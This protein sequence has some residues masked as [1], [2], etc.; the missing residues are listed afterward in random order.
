MNPALA[1]CIVGSLRVTGPCQEPLARLGNFGR[2]EWERT[3][4]WLDDS[5][6][7]LYLLER[8]DRAGAHSA[9]PESIRA[10]LRQNL[11]SNRQRLAEMKR[12][13]EF[14]NGRFEAAG[15]EFAALKGFAL[16][17]D[18]CP[19][20]ALRLQYDYDY[21]VRPECEEIARRTLQTA[22]YAHKVQSPGREPQ[23]AA[24]FVSE[25]LSLPSADQDFY[26]AALPRRV[27]LHQG[28]WEPS[29]DRV[30]PDVPR[31]V[32]DRRRPVESQ[33]MRFPAL[34]DEDALLFQVLH[35]FHHMLDHWCRPACFLE[36]AY[37][38]SR[39]H[40]RDPFWDRFRSRVEDRRYLPEIAGLVFSMATTLFGAPVPDE[41]ARW[42][43]RSSVLPLWVREY[44]ER[45][46]VAP[47]PGSKLSLFMH[48]E[49]VGDPGVWKS[50]R[51][52]RLLPLHRP[53]QVAEAGSD[54][55]A[56]RWNA[57][58]DQWRFVLR[59]VKFHLGALLNYAWH[60]PH[61]KRALRGVRERP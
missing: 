22:G 8:V 57:K 40:A 47:F 15:V 45:W 23:G 51:R 48:S 30:R 49:F 26:G 38:V 17:P 37:F 10:R 1:R 3:L 7:A 52:S 43:A 32:L 33:G 21:L 25:P 29:G 28:L 12:E 39:Q 54:G 24:L 53:A 50:V 44:G 18:F 55:V 60:L 31:D 13:F 20:A 34:A 36:I 9:V 59:R 14:F 11:A 4:S 6:L 5:G 58:W 35:A 27:E 2:P 56:S 41:V 19:D 16:V 46:A 42:S 61:W